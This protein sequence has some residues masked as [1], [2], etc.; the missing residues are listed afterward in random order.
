MMKFPRPRTLTINK[1]PDLQEDQPTILQKLVADLINP[2]PKSEM[3]RYIDETIKYIK[4][5]EKESS[6]KVKLFN[7]NVW[8]KL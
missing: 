3:D 1:Y 4:N 8:K 5:K 7:V 6:K 2:V